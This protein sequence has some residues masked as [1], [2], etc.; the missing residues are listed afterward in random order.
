VLVLSI[1]SPFPERLLNAGI[2][3]MAAINNTKIK[4]AFALSSYPRKGIKTIPL[5]GITI[6]KKN[7]RKLVIDS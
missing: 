3:V 1:A 2:E 6:D 7:I 5:I 4:P